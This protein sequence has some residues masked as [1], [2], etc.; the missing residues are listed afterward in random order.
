V[1]RYRADWR[2]LFFGAACL[3]FFVLNWRHGG[4][5]PVYYPALIFFSFSSAIMA[6]NHNH[7]PMWKNTGLNIL[8]THFLSFFYGHPVTVWVP[9]HNQ[10]HHQ[11]NNKP[12]D[13]SITYRLTGGNNIFAV[14]SYNWMSSIVEMNGA[15]KYFW[16]L[17]KTNFKSF[18]LI[19]IEYLVWISIM[20]AFFLYDWQKTIFY[21]LIP[22][23]V[24]LL[25]IHSFNFMQH[26]DTDFESKTNH[27]RNFLG[28]FGN[29]ILFNNGFH[30][31]HHD[32]MKLHWSELPEAHAKIH[33]TI[34]P[35]LNE[36]DPFW[37]YIRTFIL[38]IRPKPVRD[39]RVYRREWL[40]NKA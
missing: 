12:G 6:H 17:R 29:A 5:H 13:W 34:D 14:I 30:T 28:A 18:T 2:T 21:V 20:T 16:G 26:V 27:S 40:E 1:L 19:S 3:T 33:H 4:F 25:M 9:V 31:A 10:N 35:R 8:W 22:G 39:L 36:V 37:Y 23:Q 38:M 7:V 11:F 24:T 32:N 15:M